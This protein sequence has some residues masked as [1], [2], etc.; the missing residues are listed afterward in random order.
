MGGMDGNAGPRAIVWTEQ[1]RAE[2][3]RAVASAVGLRVVGAGCAAKGRSSAVASVFGCAA[4]DDLRSA[5]TE[6]ECD[7]VVIGSAGD[8]GAVSNPGDAGAVLA[9]RQRGVRVVTLDPL[10][11]S[12]MELSGAWSAS[13]PG[14]LRAV[15]AAVFVPLARTGRSCREAAE[16]LEMFG[17]PRTLLVEACC[18]PEE[19]TLGARLF[20]AVEVLVWLMGEPESVDAAYASPERGTLV[21]LPGETLRDAHGDITANFRFVDGRAA[22]LLASDQAARWG[23]TITMLGPGGRL[24]VFDDGFEWV[25]AD[26]ERVDSSRQ[27]KRRGETPDRSAGVATMAEAVTRLL[28]PAIPDEGP[29]DHAAVLAVCQAVLL[30]TRTGSA[31]SP[32]TIR[33]MMEVS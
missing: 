2:V 5:L 10:P 27:V 18:R 22:A 3:L 23:R 7:I 16:V 20:S 8:F 14:G 6:G 28:D 32:S 9:A 29:V 11:A 13:G 31:E 12:A 21:P 4:V 33:R 26:G 30:S 25:G 1:G 24:R 15:D 17:K 19:G